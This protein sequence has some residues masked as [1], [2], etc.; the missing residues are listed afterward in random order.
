MGNKELNTSLNSLAMKENFAIDLNKDWDPIPKVS[1][2]LLGTMLIAV[3]IIGF[4]SSIMCLI[5]VKKFLYVNR[6]NKLI[7]KLYAIELILC[8]TTCLI[9]HMILPF[10]QNILSCFLSLSPPWIL[11]HIS[12]NTAMCISSIRYYTKYKA[13]QSEIVPPEYSISFI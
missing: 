5:Y 3:S 1:G 11:N 4:L 8:F 12:T 6:I 10:F 13:V 9:G 2:S 7:L